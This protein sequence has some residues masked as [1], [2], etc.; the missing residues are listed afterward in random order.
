MSKVEILKDLR[1]IVVDRSENPTWPPFLCNR[2]IHDFPN[3]GDE[4][5]ELQAEVKEIIAPWECI[6]S[7]LAQ[8]CNVGAEWTHRG[9]CFRLGLIDGL[10]EKYSTLGVT[11]KS[12]PT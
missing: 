4:K 5:L 6:E 1:Q 12:S 10:I 2:L 7:F 11:C 8:D 3:A 9:N